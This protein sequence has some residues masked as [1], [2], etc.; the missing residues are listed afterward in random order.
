M[1]GRQGAD[2]KFLSLKTVLLLTLASAK[3]MD[4]THAL[5]VHLSYPQFF[6]GDMRMVL[7]PNSAF[8]PKVVAS[9][10]PIDL[11]AFTTA[12]EDQRAHALFPVRVVRIYVDRTRRFRR[13]DR[14]FVSWA[15]PRADLSKSNASPTG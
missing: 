10:S 7:K 3:H 11:A 6:T 4:D 8:V 5:S 14:L 1:G 12:L 15:S 13:R 9:F 2:L